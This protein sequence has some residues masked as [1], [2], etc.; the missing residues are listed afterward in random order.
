MAEQNILREYLISLGFKV[1]GK[2]EKD[3][4]TNLQLW[5]KRANKLA[6]SLAG[7]ATAAAAFVGEFSY[8]MERLYYSSKL[9]D[10]AASNLQSL[11]FAGKQVG[12]KNFTE[13]VTNLARQIRLNP[14]IQGLIQSLGIPVEGRDR[15]EVMKDLVRSLN[16]MPEY[17]AARFAGL[18]GI[19]PD[20]LHLLRT[21]IE[22]LDK[23]QARQK[24]IAAEMGLNVDEAA[25]SGVELMREWR[26][27]SEYIIDAKDSLVVHFLPKVHEFAGVMKDVLKDWVEIARVADTAGKI[28]PASAAQSGLTVDEQKEIARRGPKT[29]S[30]MT[31]DEREAAGMGRDKPTNRD[32]ARLTPDERGRFGMPRTEDELPWY[33]RWSNKIFDSSL[34]AAQY[35]GIAAANPEG[36]ELSSNAKERLGM[37]RTRTANPATAGMATRMKDSALDALNYRSTPRV[38]FDPAAVDAATE[39]A[40]RAPDV[41]APVTVPQGA[42]PPGV[43]ETQFLKHPREEELMSQLEAAK[44]LPPGL[45]DYIWRKESTRGQHMLSPAGAK[46]HFGFMDATAADYGLKNPNDFGSSAQA[47]AAYM[48][49]LT[50]KYGD[51]RFALAAYNWGQGNLDALMKRT[52]AQHGDWS[53]DEQDRYVLGHLPAETRKYIAGLEPGAAGGAEGANITVNA[54]TKIDVHETSS[55]SDTA[56]MIADSQ[57]QVFGDVARQLS[58][59]IR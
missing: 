56:N 45:L 19:D 8:R 35:L 16:A 10:S 24:E 58:D 2:G 29:W 57:R 3:L 54:N 4:D 48:K 55:A 59:K 42:Q 1:D 13:Q 12:I 11:D 31:P 51:L 52:M 26:E 43:P 32:W 50:S 44:G 39:P 15:G 36:A 53:Q 7:V 41:L 34:A 28:T 6:H 23:W 40:V 49:D 22:E 47:A 25:K 14:G 18:F 38:P 21:E 5:D 30:Q 33:T 46:G 37:D 20:S 9:A 17:V 27:V